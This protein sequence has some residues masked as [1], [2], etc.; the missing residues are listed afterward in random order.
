MPDRFRS[1][2]PGT[3]IFESLAELYACY[4]T[5]F[6]QGHDYRRDLQ[7]VCGIN[8]T[9]FDR[10]F[11][12]LIELKR[13]DADCLVEQF[14]IQDE[15]TRILAQTDGWGPYQCTMSRAT[16]LGAALDT[17]LRPD[18]V[19]EIENPKTATLAFF[20]HYGNPPYPVTFALLG[21]SASDGCLIPVTAFQTRM[22][23]ARKRYTEWSGGIVWQ[24]G[25]ECP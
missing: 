15:K 9:A 13:Q 11:L 12:H 20:K 5:L 18:A 1:P 23:Q 7:S 4:R 3:L 22:R 19:F 21:P 25:A 10:N 8:F 24:R 2:R 14:N 16:N 6:L 17:Y